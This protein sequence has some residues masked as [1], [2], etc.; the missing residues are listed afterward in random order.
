METNTNIPAKRTIAIVAA[1]IMIATTIPF[2]M[3]IFIPEDLTAKINRLEVEYQTTSEQI[4]E[5]QKTTDALVRSLVDIRLKLATA[6]TMTALD[7]ESFDLNELARL[8]EVS[9]S[10]VETLHGAPLDFPSE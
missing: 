7:S 1:S 2:V 8:N 5:S 3:A 6:K 9:A 10:S 4:V